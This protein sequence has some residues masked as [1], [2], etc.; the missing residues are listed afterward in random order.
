MKRKRHGT[1]EIISNLR[2]GGA[3]EAA[4]TSAAEVYQTLEVSAAMPA[5]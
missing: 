4:N 2:E 5:R 1:G 3:M